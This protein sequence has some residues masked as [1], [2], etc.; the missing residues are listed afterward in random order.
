MGILN[1][2]KKTRIAFATGVLLFASPGFT[3]ES[4]MIVANYPD[5][6]LNLSTSAIRNLFMGSPLDIELTPVNL[7]A[8]NINRIQFN[9]RVIGLT[10]SR[11]QSYWAQMRFSGRKQAPI[12]L[13]DE[14]DVVN[15]VSSNYGAIAYLPE[16]TLLPDN[17]QV[18]LVIK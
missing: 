8:G 13:V 2:M 3:Q 11:I 5:Q 16:G 6:Q 12:E 1:K 17:V 14:E 15:F 10:E 4:I 7:P 18:L 9:T